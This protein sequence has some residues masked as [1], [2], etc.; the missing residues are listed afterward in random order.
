MILPPVS[1]V[2]VALQRRFLNLFLLCRC[3]VAT[4]RVLAGLLARPYYW[5]RASIFPCYP[6]Q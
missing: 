4:R 3:N 2:I 6:S 5:L 1:D